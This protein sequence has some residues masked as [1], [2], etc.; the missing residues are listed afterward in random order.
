MCRAMLDFHL[1]STTDD[2]ARHFYWC[3][4]QEQT[5]SNILISRTDLEIAAKNAK[6][7]PFYFGDDDNQRL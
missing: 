4:N 3:S 7:D 1:A 5:K 2:L 6:D